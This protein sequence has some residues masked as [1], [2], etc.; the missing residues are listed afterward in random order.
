MA[1]VNFL[2]NSRLVRRQGGIGLLF[3]I[4]DNNRITRLYCKHFKDK[5]S[6]IKIWK[7]VEN[8]LKLSEMLPKKRKNA[9]ILVKYQLSAQGCWKCKIVRSKFEKVLSA[10]GTGLTIRY[11][12]LLS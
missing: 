8:V 12:S 9:Q 10:I 5:P 7:I 11:I 1:L 3:I 2:D 6:C 4:R